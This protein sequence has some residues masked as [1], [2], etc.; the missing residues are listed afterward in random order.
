MT[1]V[2]NELL[3][4]PFGDMV[5]ELAVS[6]AKAQ[7]NLDREGLE[8]LKVMGD[9]KQAPVYLPTFDINTNAN[10][11][12]DGFLLEDEVETSM[13]GAGFQPTFYQFAETIIEVKMTITVTKDNTEEIAKKGK[14]TSVSW[15]R[16][17]GLS[18][19][20]TPVD[21]KYTNKYNYSQEGTSLIRTRLVPV[22]PNSM[23]QKQ[24]D[25][26]ADVMKMMLESK[27]SKL[28]DKLNNVAANEG[29]NG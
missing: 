13:I 26:R 16:G 9:K 19:K 2:G 5:T 14:E 17:R 12:E 3:D 20:S 15:L 4:V 18:I 23:I 28:E 8:I 22:P 1:N 21:A 7:A 11:N 6:I 25:L 10:P 24:I 29:N 27:I